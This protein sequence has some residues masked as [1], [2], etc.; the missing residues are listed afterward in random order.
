MRANPDVSQFIQ[1]HN[2]HLNRAIASGF[3]FD[4]TISRCH[5]EK[6][7]EAEGEL[8]FVWARF[9]PG[10]CGWLFLRT[11]LFEALVSLVTQLSD[12]PVCAELSKQLS[13][14]AG[15]EVA[16]KATFDRN[17]LRER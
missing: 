5:I 10:G 3:D 4:T 8:S 11:M 9:T 7:I 17:G 12:D 15:V 16:T 6:S 2:F 14:P 1:T 13:Q